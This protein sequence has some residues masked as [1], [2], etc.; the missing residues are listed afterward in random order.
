ML[1]T[2]SKNR[3][4]GKGGFLTAMPSGSR[5]RLGTLYGQFVCSNLVG[6]GTAKSSFFICK[7]KLQGVKLMVSISWHRSTRAKQ[8][9]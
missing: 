8:M 6:G 2:F 1:M 7:V 5:R 3:P 9:M 4:E